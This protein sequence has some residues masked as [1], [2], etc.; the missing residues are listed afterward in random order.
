MKNIEDALSAIS[1]IDTTIDNIKNIGGDSIRFKGYIIQQI[2]LPG[3]MKILFGEPFSIVTENYY[4]S[5]NNYLIFGNSVNSLRDFINYYERGKTL[6]RDAHFSA[7]MDNLNNNSNIIVYSNIA[8]SKEIYKAFVSN[9]TAN[10]IDTHK[11]LL[12]KF[13]AV[14]IQISK[15]KN[16]LFYNN[17]Y[18][19]RSTISVLN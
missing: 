19:N 5:I 10:D 1:K 6:A 13:E 3:M 7:F 8:R 2:N 14:A 16:N 18:I 4:T 17:I 9:E 11:E 12:N 15:S